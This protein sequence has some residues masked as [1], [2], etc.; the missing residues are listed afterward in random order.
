MY[1]VGIYA[2]FNNWSVY[3]FITKDPRSPPGY[4]QF[5]QDKCLLNTYFVPGYYTNHQDHEDKTDRTLTC[6]GELSNI[7]KQ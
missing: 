4:H 6:K 1:S 5:F 2:Q 3:Y 7:N